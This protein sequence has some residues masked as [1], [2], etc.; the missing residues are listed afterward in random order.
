MS[1]PQIRDQFDNRARAWLV[2]GRFIFEIWPTGIGKPGEEPEEIV[3]PWEYADEF[4][5]F[6]IKHS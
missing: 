6:I 3:I 5:R 2:D 1:A 4:A